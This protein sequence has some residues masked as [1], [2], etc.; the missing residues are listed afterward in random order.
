MTSETDDHLGSGWIRR[1][2]IEMLNDNLE[3][4]AVYHVFELTCHLDLREGE[5]VGGECSL[6]E[7]DAVAWFV[8]SGQTHGVFSV[9]PWMVGGAGYVAE[10]IARWDDGYPKL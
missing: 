1:I 6:A 7:A 10:V 2:H 5:S 8:S 4:L 9:R 3:S